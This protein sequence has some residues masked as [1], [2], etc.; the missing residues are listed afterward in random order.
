MPLH[1]VL[2]CV[3]VMLMAKG[4]PL[5]LTKVNS[6]VA[7][8]LHCAASHVLM[9]SLL[10]CCLCLQH[11]GMHQQSLTSSIL[12]VQFDSVQFDGVLASWLYSSLCF[13]GVVGQANQ[14]SLLIQQQLS[15]LNKE[16]AELT[17]RS[18]CARGHVSMCMVQDSR[19][20][21]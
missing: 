14:T 18:A 8:Y 4:T 2:R 1:A 19:S 10:L 6:V 9:Y 15:Q 5:M 3:D 16:I 17:S 21:T 7:S 13:V 11:T 12:N 20:V